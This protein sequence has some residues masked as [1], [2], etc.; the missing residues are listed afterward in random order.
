[1][2]L[3]PCFLYRQYTNEI[4]LDACNVYR[5]FI[6]DFFRIVWPLYNFLWEYNKL[7][8][9]D[10]TTAALD[11]SNTLKSMLVKSPFLALPQPYRSFIIDNDTFI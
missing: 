6:K 9:L 3:R 4:I 8:L 2:Q 5:K 1:M 10:P 11:A 7:N